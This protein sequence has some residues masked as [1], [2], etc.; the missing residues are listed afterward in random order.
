MRILLKHWRKHWKLSQDENEVVTFKLL[1]R[2]LYA[3][4]KDSFTRFLFTHLK[5]C[6]VASDNQRICYR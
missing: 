2:K 4:R 3:N 5:P 6:S 1:F